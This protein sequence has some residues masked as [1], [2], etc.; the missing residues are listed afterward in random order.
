MRGKALIF[1]VFLMGAGPVFGQTTDLVT[2]THPWKYHNTGT[3]PAEDWMQPGYDDSAWPSGNGALGFPQNENLLIGGAG[4]NT[5]LSSNN[6]AGLFIIAY[7]FRTTFV[8]PTTNGISLTSSN[9]LDDGAVIYVN[10]REVVRPGMPGGPV[11]D[12]TFAFPGIEISGSGAAV[13]P[14]PLDFVK[15][16]TN[17]IAVE[18]HQVT[19]NSSDMILGM[20]L[21]SVPEPPEPPDPAAPAITVHPRDT[22][23]DAGNV[24]QFSV[25]A[26]G[27]SPLTYR[28][29]TNGV[30]IPGQISPNVTRTT[31]LAMDGTVYHA[32]VSN[33]LGLATSSNA[34]LTVV[35]DVRGPK[36]ISAIQ[37]QSNA[38]ELR[39][40]EQITQASGQNISNYVVHVLGTTNTLVVTQAQ[41]GI[42]LTRIRVN[43]NLDPHTSYAACI[44]NFTDARDNVSSGDCMAITPLP[45]TNQVVQLGGEWRLSHDAP[46]SASWKTASFDDSGWITGNG[47]FWNATNAPATCSPPGSRIQKTRTQYYRQR[48]TAPSTSA[49][50]VTLTIQHVADDGAVLYVNGFEVGRYNMGPGSVEYDTLPSATVIGPPVCV[51]ISTNVP[52]SL[53]LAGANVLAAEVHQSETD[54]E[55]TESDLAFD[56]ALSISYRETPTIIPALKITHPNPTTVRVVWIGNGWRLERSTAADGAPWEI[57]SPVS[58]VQGTNSFTDTVS[59]KRFYRLQNP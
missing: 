34:V 24:A 49:T 51:T 3:L 46:V 58:T 12:S 15:V 44:Y 2:W 38:V 43:S 1:S 47:L 27:E 50:N 16:G 21:V 32:T 29:Y 54:L 8:L 11:T 33:H 39:F 18:V 25:E 19:T 52:R 31:T 26:F 20:R 9:L 56:A 30:L 48:F 57:A 6:A 53:L 5:V 22:K 59:D 7:Y 35:P 36:M 41:W 37:T 23:V 28:W 4:V 13:H 45:V 10:G 55:R 40:N 14:I 17:V 42:S